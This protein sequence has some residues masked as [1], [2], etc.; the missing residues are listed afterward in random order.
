VDKSVWYGLNMEQRMN[1]KGGG[2]GSNGGPA[3]DPSAQSSTAPR[4][5]SSVRGRADAI[6]NAP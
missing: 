2:S 6:L 4:A 3:T 1:Y 5:Q